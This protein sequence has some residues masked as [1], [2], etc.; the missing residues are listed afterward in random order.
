MFRMSL[1]CFRCFNHLLASAALHQAN[2]RLCDVLCLGLGVLCCLCS[3]F[4]IFLLGFAITC[5]V[6]QLWTLMKKTLG[7][8]KFGSVADWSPFDDPHTCYLVSVLLRI[9]LYLTPHNSI[10]FVF[11]LSL[12]SCKKGHMTNCWCVFAA[13]WKVKGSDGFIQKSQSW[14]L[15]TLLLSAT[16]LNGIETFMS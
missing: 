5:Y 15:F 13:R 10:S 9:D 2:W 14:N 7:R 12:F 1:S 4:T 8:G 6:K 3:P 11:P 16:M